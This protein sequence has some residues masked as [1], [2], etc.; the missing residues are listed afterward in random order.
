MNYYNY[1]KSRVRKYYVDC[2]PFG[3]ELFEKLNTLDYSKFGKAVMFD[4][5]HFVKSEYSLHRSL[6]TE[7]KTKFA[8]YSYRTSEA[9]IDTDFVNTLQIITDVYRMNI[10]ITNG[11]FS[12]GVKSI[13]M[14]FKN[15]DKNLTLNNKL[16]KPY[17]NSFDNKGGCKDFKVYFLY[18]NYPLE[19]QFHTK[20]SEE[21]N[22]NTHGIYEVIRSLEDGNEMKELLRED[23][24]KLYS[25][26]TIPVFNDKAIIEEVFR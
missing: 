6:I 7:M 4:K 23:R 24:D 13:L 17:K 9:E 19:I 11:D 26:V 8:K 18:K 12:L 20:E 5:E 10:E 15:I 25:T 16:G 21:M 14:L 3:M 2:F 22:L 1:I